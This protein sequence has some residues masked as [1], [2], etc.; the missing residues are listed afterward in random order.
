M[1]SDEK[2]AGAPD[3]NVDAGEN[4]NG[5]SAP[6]ADAVASAGNANT[7]ADVCAT[8][9]NDTSALGA[10]ANIDTPTLRRAMFDKQYAAGKALSTQLDSDVTHPREV[11]ESFLFELLEKN[12]NTPFGKEHNFADINTVADFKRLVPFTTYDDYAGYIYEAME[13]G[14]TELMTTDEVIHFNETSGTMGNPKGVPY[15]QRMADNLMGYAGA[16]TFYKTYAATGD[17]LA[18]GRMFTMM[19]CSLRTLKG[20]L[21]YGALSS[22]STMDNS[23]F[24]SVTTTS[25]KE[26]VFPETN[27]DTRYLHTRFALSEPDIRDISVVFITKLL[28][29]MRYIEGSWRMLVQDIETGAIDA[30]VQ[31]P[32]DVREN[33]QAQIA[34][35]PERARELREIFERGFDVPIAPQ[36]WPRLTVIRSV[37]GGGFTP[38]TQRL[39][40][41][42][43][44]DV[45]IMYT[46]YSASEG[47]FSVPYEMDNPASVM[48]PRSVYF[49]FVSVDNPDYE[50]TLGVEDLEEGK[51]YEVIITSGSGFYR[52][53]MRDAVRC[54]G[55][56]GKMPTIEFLYRLDQTVN[57]VGEKTSE[58]VLRKM[59]DSIAKRM[60]FDLVDFSLYPNTEAVP[61]RYEFLFEFYNV[62]HSKIDMDELARVT[63]EEVRAAA[64]SVA[65]E[66]DG[67][68]MGDVVVHVLQDETY[69][70]WVDMRVA[71]G[72]VDN[73]I[74]PVHIIDTDQKHRFFYALIDADLEA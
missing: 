18:G 6:S 8:S 33:L 45:H 70:L 48:L 56:M 22:K 15:T 20:G 9:A 34:P 63:N 40:R 51:D 27:T 3:V 54:V 66:I 61:P 69:Q 1:A 12:K 2:M 41:F 24:L 52:Y 28:D 73:Q 11:Q 57:L 10:N 26:A 30:S 38:Y 14:K 71:H 25:P 59:A 31:L 39:R 44:A 4:V 32:A 42:I 13:H 21:T 35:N 72:K 37:A 46:G 55:H 65:E 36:I 16:Y 19:Q 47:A 74:K 53:K 7:S 60:S 5:V 62:D 68:A 67:G 50:H 43:G 64:Y 49:E 58:M 17:T 29:I 23:Q